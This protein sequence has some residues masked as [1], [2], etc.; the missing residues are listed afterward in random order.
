MK[1]SSA[2]KPFSKF[3]YPTTKWNNRKAKIHAEVQYYAGN[4]QVHHVQAL[5]MRQTNDM[6]SC[7]STYRNIDSHLLL[8]PPRFPTLFSFNTNT[9]FIK[10]PTS[11]V[12]IIINSPCDCT[13]NQK[14]KKETECH[15]QKSI[16]IVYA[17]NRAKS[18]VL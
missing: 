15:Y 1:L 11:P 6:T 18:A 5:I 3:F 2:K 16:T 9:S 8:I 4:N 17:N 14:K 13:S 12:I 10:K 7:T